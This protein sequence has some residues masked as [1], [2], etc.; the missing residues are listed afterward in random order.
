[1]KLLA[2]TMVC[3]E[4]SL[5]RFNGKYRALLWGGLL[6]TALVSGMFAL[7][8][9]DFRFTNVD[10]LAKKTNAGVQPHDLVLVSPWQLGITFNHYFNGACAWETVPPLADHSC[11][12][13]DLLKFQMQNTNAMRPVLQKISATLTAGG[14]VWIVGGVGEVKGEME[15]SAPPVPPL[16]HSGWQETPY[17]LLWNNQL[18]WWLRRHSQQIICV[19][20][21][22]NLDVNYNERSSLYQ[23]SGWRE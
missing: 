17:G 11:H 18:S 15:P 4:A 6:A 3:F 19:D 16:P 7:R 9:L 5:P 8:V 10:T 21:G 14:A 1:M 20:A 23:A 22:T 12:R 2:L 13:Y